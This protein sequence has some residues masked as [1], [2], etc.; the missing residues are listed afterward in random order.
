[1]TARRRKARFIIEVLA[2]ASVIGTMVSP[3]VAAPAAPGLLVKA[4]GKDVTDSLPVM[5]ENG[6]SWV[7]VRQAA[8]LL[9]ATVQWSDGAVTVQRGHSVLEFRVG[10]SQVSE[11]GQTY[12]L[13]GDVR[14]IGN[15]TYVP[16]RFLAERL[17][18]AVSWDGVRQIDLEPSEKRQQEVTRIEDILRQQNEVTNTLK[19]Y[20]TDMNLTLQ[21][22]AP[23]AGV[24]QSIR[25]EGGFEIL[26]QRD[27]LAMAAKG[28]ISATNLPGLSGPVTVDAYLADN[29]VYFQNPV[30]G[31][32]YFIPVDLSLLKEWMAQGA[33][34]PEQR[35][36]ISLMADGAELTDQGDAYMIAGDMD[37]SMMARMADVLNQG[38]GQPALEP[39]PPDVDMSVHYD[40]TVDKSGMHSRSFRIVEQVAVA[41]EFQFQWILSGTTDQIN[42]V[43]PVVVPDE[44]KQKAV[45]LD[46]PELPEAPGP[47]L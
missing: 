2:A 12:D 38:T 37:K 41:S 26:Y 19:S 22:S 36:V 5:V 13:P 16:L 46:I 24:N 32:W 33:D 20:A 17:G 1:M 42:Q 8:A 31:G 14:L 43:P 15:S 4:E 29:K 47:S 27:P 39:L 44:V 28:K 45:P 25:A 6:V 21:G 40:I 11:G 34:T 30:G 10:S 7:P 9:H 35:R 23:M 3:A 18:Y